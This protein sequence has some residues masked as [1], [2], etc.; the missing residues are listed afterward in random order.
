MVEPTIFGPHFWNAIHYMCVGAPKKLSNEDKRYY[1]LF[2][3]NLQY[4]IPCDI[5]SE[6]Y[7]K[8]IKKVNIDK[9]LDNNNLFEFSVDLHNIVNKMLG[10]REW[11][12]EEAYQKY[13]YNNTCNY[14]KYHIIIE[15]FLMILIIILLVLLLQK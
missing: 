4:W 5:C 11:T 7:E 8:N 3:N 1:K 13:K 12:I 10:K 14:N 6:H 15:V 2:F 9:Y